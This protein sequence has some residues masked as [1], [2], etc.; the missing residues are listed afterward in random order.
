ML[1]YYFPYIVNRM[2]PNQVLR[3]KWSDWDKEEGKM[4]VSQL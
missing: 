4:R 1:L 2:E 3:K